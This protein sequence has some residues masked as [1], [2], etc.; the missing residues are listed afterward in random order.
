MDFLPPSLYS[1]LL[2]S[3]A[4]RAYCYLHKPYQLKLTMILPILLPSLMTFLSKFVEQKIIAYC[5]NGAYLCDQV[6][7]GPQKVDY[8]T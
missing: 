6:G 4:K 1:T 7:K 8:E 3:Y 5:E 2:A